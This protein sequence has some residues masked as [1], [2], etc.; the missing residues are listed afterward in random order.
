MPLY[1]LVCD[2]G[3]I[4]EQILKL[5]EKEPV[6]DKCGLRMRRTMSTP[7]FILKGHNWSKD[8]YGLKDVKNKGDK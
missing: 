7:V 8:N 3:H 6:C 5:N 1:E 4:K 2:C